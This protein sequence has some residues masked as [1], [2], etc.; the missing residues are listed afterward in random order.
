MR[1]N[2]VNNEAMLDES[3][4]CLHGDEARGTRITLCP[5]MRKPREIL[6]RNDVMVA[7]RCGVE[8][9]QDHSDEEVHEHVRDRQCKAGEASTEH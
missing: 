5:V 1:Y 3:L 6:L 9:I 7:R 2:E 4:P 8:A